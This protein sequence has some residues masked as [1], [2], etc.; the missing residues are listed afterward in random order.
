MTEREQNTAFY[1]SE[2][3]EAYKTVDELDILWDK[4]CVS[5]CGV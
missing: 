3:T 4:E 1:I 5:V 2:F